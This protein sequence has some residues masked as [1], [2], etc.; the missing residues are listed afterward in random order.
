MILPPVTLA[1][2]IMGDG[3]FNGITLLL[4]TDS[5]WIRELVLLINVLIINMIYIVIS[6]ILNYIYL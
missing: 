5:Y 4:C 1:H 3:T 6:V 2:W